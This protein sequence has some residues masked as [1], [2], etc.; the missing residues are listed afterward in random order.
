MDSELISVLLSR[1]DRIETAL[2]S[3]LQQ[4]SA[5]DWYTT[6][7]IAATLGRSPYTVREWARKGLVPAEKAQNGRGWLISQKVLARLRNGEL[8]LPE[9]GPGSV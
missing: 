7:E 3:L 4:P 8:P 5:K 9:R 1:L 2:A 6:E